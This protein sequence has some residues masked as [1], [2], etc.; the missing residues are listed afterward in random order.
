MVFGGLGQPLGRQH[1]LDDLALDHRA[2][3]FLGHF[4]V[5]LGRQHDGFDGDRLAGFVVAEGDLALRI[6]TQ[7]RQHAVL[8]QFRL[9]LHQTVSVVDR[10]RHEGVGLVGGVTEHQA[11][12]ARA[13]IFRLGAIDA[14]GD[15]DAL[16]AD[17]VEDTTGLAVEADVGRGIA[18]IGDDTTY[19]LLEIHPRAGGDLT[20]HDGNACL[21]ER[22]ARHACLLVARDDGIEHGVGNLVGNLVR[23]P[24]GHGLGC[25]E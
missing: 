23:M 6:R 24:F 15:I 13:L 3:V 14:L 8:A 11:L 18:D 17:Q 21:D 12:V 9:T 2:Q 7:P 5:M 25:E 20:G 4:R 1:L 10:R 19:Q 22:F 16:L